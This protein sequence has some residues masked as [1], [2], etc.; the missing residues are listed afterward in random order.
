MECCKSGDAAAFIPTTSAI[1]FIYEL[2][3]ERTLSKVSCFC[4]SHHRNEGSTVFMTRAVEN[5]AEPSAPHVGRGVQSENVFPFLQ[6][7]L[8]NFAAVRQTMRTRIKDIVWKMK[9][10][11]H[12]RT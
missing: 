1:I 11:T 10:R 4:Q 7:L 6:G 12:I 5:F 8:L 2:D 9:I 3:I